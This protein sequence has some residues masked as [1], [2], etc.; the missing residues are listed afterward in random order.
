MPSH[1]ARARPTRS[2]VEP[3]PGNGLRLVSQIMVDKPMTYRRDKIRTPFG[4]M[5]DDT[6][7]HDLLVTRIGG[8]EQGLAAT[9]S[10]ESG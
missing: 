9:F 5:D 8:D 1:T 4:R 3:S 6:I 7:V 2:T 10:S